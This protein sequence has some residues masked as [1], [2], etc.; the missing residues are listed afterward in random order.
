[1]VSLFPY[2]VIPNTINGSP[3][4]CWGLQ[5]WH[6]TDALMSQTTIQKVN[7]CIS[8][9][10]IMATI[11][12]KVLSCRCIKMSLQTRVELRAI[13][14]SKLKGAYHHILMWHHVTC[15]LYS[16]TVD[17]LTK[18]LAIRLSLEIQSNTGMF[19][20]NTLLYICHWD[21]GNHN[22]QL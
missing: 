16:F 10:F 9:I 15:Y 22:V 5:G 21:P 1:M 3:T 11:F 13:C 18:Y 17:H 8:H 6:T 20:K 4:W 7:S 12:S 19:C 14:L 2:W